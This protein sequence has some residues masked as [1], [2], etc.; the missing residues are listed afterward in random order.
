MAVK[1]IIKIIL[2]ILPITMVAA[3]LAVLA[4]NAA[5]DKLQ[6]IGS[7][8]GPYSG[9][10]QDS[11]AIIMGM[12]VKGFLS[13]LGVIFLWLMLYAGFHWMTAR[14]DEQKVEK[15]QSTITRAIIGLAITVGAYAIWAFIKS[16]FI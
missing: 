9:A 11:M 3:P 15:A 2:R 7:E 16:Y 8:Q 1:K 12:A 4:K 5:L 6:E 14:G 10:G 13:L